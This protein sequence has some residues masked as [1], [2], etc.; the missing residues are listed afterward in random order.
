[1]GEGGVGGG[2]YQPAIMASGHLAGVSRLAANGHLFGWL[3]ATNSFLTGKMVLLPPADLSSKYGLLED[4][5]SGLGGGRGKS[6]VIR[7][8]EE[9]NGGAW[10]LEDMSWQDNKSCDVL[11]DK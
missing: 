3:L 10:S 8:G 1:M 7:P 5:S 4:K 11:V 2:W 9:L 6:P